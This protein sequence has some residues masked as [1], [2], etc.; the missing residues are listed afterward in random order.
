MIT[1][2]VNAAL[3]TLGGGSPIGVPQL[4]RCDRALLVA[5]WLDLTGQRV[6]WYVPRLLLAVGIFLEVGHFRFTPHP[7]EVFEP[8]RVEPAPAQEPSTEESGAAK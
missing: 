7:D 4:V 3:R 8:R 1:K 2:P 5:L 6:P